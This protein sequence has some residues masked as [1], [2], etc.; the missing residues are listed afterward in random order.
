VA[1]RPPAK[2]NEP[3]VGVA[4]R[5]HEAVPEE[6]AQAA[7]CPGGGDDAGAGDVLHRMPA[8]LEEPSESLA[9]AWRHAELEQADGLLVH[10]PLPQVRPRGVSL[11][12][13]ETA[14]EELP[15]GLMD[16]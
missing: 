9:V 4:D 11:R 14:L 13:V 7:A 16:V 8:R 1:H 15:R 2:T 6:V 12:G 3:S 10:L 5:E